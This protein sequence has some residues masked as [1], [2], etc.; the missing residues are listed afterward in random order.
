MLAAISRGGPH[1][2][3]LKVDTRKGRRERRRL[4]DQR[5]PVVH[6]GAAAHSVHEHDD[7]LTRVEARPVD[8]HPRTKVGAA[9]RLRGAGD[10]L[11][12]DGH[13]VARCYAFGRRERWYAGRRRGGEEG[14][15]E[16][17][18]ERQVK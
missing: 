17:E 16:E 8:P 7:A 2:H 14:G 3:P 11:P 18:R 4:G 10:A 13:R 1:L 9:H 12:R 15:Q 6:R 5:A